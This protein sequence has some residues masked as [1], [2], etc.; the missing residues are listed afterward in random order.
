[1]EWIQFWQIPCKPKK[2]LYHIS[3]LSG[4]SRIY[5]TSWLHPLK[6]DLKNHQNRIWFFF[7]YI[8]I[9]K[10]LKRFDTFLQFHPLKR[11]C[12]VKYEF[13]FGKITLY[14]PQLSP[15][16]H[17]TP[18]TLKSINW[19]PKLIQLHGRYPLRPKSS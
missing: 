5:F 10:I 3:F 19:P 11:V 4:G 8:Y 16:F 2:T 6:F 13:F 18:W 17:F 1:M 9:Y 7:F 15:I 12:E 14:H